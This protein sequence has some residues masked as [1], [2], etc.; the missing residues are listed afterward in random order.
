[1]N[2]QLYRESIEELQDFQLPTAAINVQSEDGN[3]QP[4]GDYPNQV[5]QGKSISLPRYSK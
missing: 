4:F 2:P 1:V 3:V 5:Y